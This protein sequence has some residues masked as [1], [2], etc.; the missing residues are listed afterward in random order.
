VSPSGIT[1]LRV[2]Q[3]LHIGS[4][5]KELPM[6]T[7][8]TILFALVATTT[9]CSKKESATDQCEKIYQKGDGEKPYATDKA[10]FMEACEK[11]EDN[12][13]RCLLLSGKESFED[14]TCGPGNGNTFRE[15]M[16]IMKL[17]QGMK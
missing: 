7:L 13:R 3:A 11:T 17:G 15:S 2:A 16:E 5:T 14:K 9:A 4:L 10:K 1:G 6:K 12:T 8:T